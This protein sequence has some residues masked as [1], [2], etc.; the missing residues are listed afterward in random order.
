M[1]F[2]IIHNPLTF[3][4]QVIRKC[5]WCYYSPSRLAAATARQTKRAV[6][7]Y[8]ARSAP[9][10]PSETTVKSSSAYFIRCA[11]TPCFIDSTENF[12]STHTDFGPQ[13]GYHSHH[14][15]SPQGEREGSNISTST[16]QCS[17]VLFAN[18]T[19]SPT[20]SQMGHFIL[21]YRG[22]IR[23]ALLSLSVLIPLWHA[24]GRLFVVVL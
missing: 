23:Y 22:F 15:C 13:R 9:F 7:L 1:T 12:T 14:L 20:A 6:V 16:R 24:L 17:A 10:F 4:N 5:S 2:K 19:L 8:V 18:S 21:A 11:S 3:E